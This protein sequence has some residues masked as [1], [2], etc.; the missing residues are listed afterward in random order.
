M[1][2]L[3]TSAQ[4]MSGGVDGTNGTGMDTRLTYGGTWATGD[5]WT[6]VLTDASSGVETQ[7]GAGTV[8]GIQPTFVFTYKNR[9]YAIAGTTLYFCELADATVWNDPNGT[10]NG[11]IVLSD[12]FAFSQDTKSIANYQGRLAVFG[13]KNIQIW[14][15]D[16]DPTQFLQVQ[17]LENIG[18]VASESVKSLGDLDVLFLYDTGVR[19]LR[20]RDQSLNGFIVDI[21]SP[22]DTLVKSKMASA[23]ATEL[24]ASCGVIEP[25]SNRYWLFIKDTIYVLSYFPSNK[26]T[27]WT[28]YAATYSAA[29]VQTAF[30]P[31]KFVVYSGQVVIRASDAAYFYG[32]SDG[33]TYDNCV[34][35]WSTSWL[36]GQDPGRMKTSTTIGY[37]VLGAWQISLGMDPKSGTLSTIFN[38]TTLTT[39]SVAL[40]STYDIGSVPCSQYGSHFRY[41]GQTTGSTAAQVAGIHHF[42]TVGQNR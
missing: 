35:S 12:Y 11:F 25:T 26:V 18:T 33:N 8:T 34:A 37:A 14:T 42:Y 4:A 1:G 27:A 30:V 15:V 19:S 5:K 23:T 3:I 36:T 6:V 9:V 21:G 29:G 38:N 13:R 41:S 39:T 32:G 22:I 40:A 7:V 28:T 10:G 24:A 17:V 16:P 31:Q 2:L 20:V